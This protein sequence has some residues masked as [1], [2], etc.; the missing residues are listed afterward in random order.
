MSWLLLTLILSMHGSTMKLNC[1]EVV[2]DCNL[3][4]IYNSIKHNRAVS[5]TSQET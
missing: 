1:N 4:I 5:P 2:F 3:L